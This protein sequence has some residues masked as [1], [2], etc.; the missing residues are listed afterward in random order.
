MTEVKRS[1]LTLRGNEN[2][3]GKLEKWW[4]SMMLSESELKELSKNEPEEK[5]ISSA[6]SGMKARLKRCHS[7][8]AVMCS[9]GFNTLWFSLPDELR[10]QDKS[11]I[12]ESWAMIAVALVFVKENSE[13]K[14]AKSEKN[15]ETKFAE[16][17]GK[18]KDSYKP[19]VSEMRFSQLQSSKTPDE[20][21]RRLRRILQQI[22]EK[23]SVF[24]LA[25]DIEQWVREY[26]QL[27]PRATKDLI[28]VKWAMDYYK[29]ADINKS[30]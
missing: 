28:R 8:E 21:L 26:Y 1:P 19:V 7:I 17:A 14:F 6:P 25:L 30:K 22:N 18:K 15:S 20:F 2:L 27:R 24:N 3:K 4:Q 12:Y 23:F 9:E 13:T 16:A 11:V 29:S 5:K 10:E